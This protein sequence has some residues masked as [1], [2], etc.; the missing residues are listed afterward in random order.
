[1]NKNQITIALCNWLAKIDDDE[2]FDIDVFSTSVEIRMIEDEF[3]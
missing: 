3:P 1:M 2:D